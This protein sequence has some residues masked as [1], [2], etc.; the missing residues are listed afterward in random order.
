M[1]ILIIHTYYQQTGGEDAV[2]R[3]ESNL[4]S[5]TEEIKEI[6]FFNKNGWKG[7]VDFLCSIWNIGA[8]L[9]VKKQIEQF[10]PDIIHLHNWHFAAGP[11]I[12]RVAKKNKIPVV[13]TLHNYRLLCPSATLLQNGKLFTESV[14]A[15]FPWKAVFKKVYR[16]SLLQTFWLAFVIWFH[17]KIG[18]WKLADKYIVLTDFAKQLVVNSSFGVPEEKFVVKSNFVEQQNAP[19]LKRE[20]HF[21]FIGRLSE[22]KGIK[23]L[24]E[25]FSNQDLE[26]HIAGDGPLKDEIIRMSRTNKNIHYLGRLDKEGISTVMQQC[27]ALIFPS[28]WYEGMPMT[29]LEAFSMGTPV[30]ASN[31]GAMAS[32]IQNGFNGFHF[33]AGNA[34]SLQ[35]QLINWE[36]LTENEKES[37]RINALET[38]KR[39]YTP[40]QNKK[41]LISIYESVISE[42]TSH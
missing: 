10:N 8:A 38:Y 32:M 4:L 42:K 24:L 41:Q 9:D 5:D 3:Q 33:E 14:H 34:K 28:I 15:K 6:C 13:I 1:K 17:K 30:L 31:I 29:L 37:Y 26:L 19:S 20:K 16:N 18:T 12:I 36:K 7:A 39:N 23:V 11:L 27:S 25:A 35:T 21:L 22:E 40:E 2:F